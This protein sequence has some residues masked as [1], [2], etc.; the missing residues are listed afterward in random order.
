MGR[1]R[2]G[3]QVIMMVA[4]LALPEAVSAQG[5]PQGGTPVQGALQAPTTMVPLPTPA[6]TLEFDATIQA[7]ID[8]NPTVLGAA[9]NISRAEALLMQ[10]RAIERP[11]ASAS[12]SDVTINTSAVIQGLVISPRS[13]VTLTGD[14]SFAVLSAAKWAQVAQA[15]DQVDVAKISTADVRRQVAVAAA[16]AYLAVFAAQRQLA[17]D[18]R[19]VS[20]AQAHLDYAQKRLQ[21]G[22]GS[23]LDAQRAA[24]VVSTDQAL[25]ENTRLAL[26]R[27]EEA[28]GVLVATDG[29]VA[30]GA[31]PVFETPAS[32]DVAQGL[33]ARTDVQLQRENTRADERVLRDSGK[34]WWPTGTISFDPT[35]IVPAGLFQLSK[36]WRLSL[37]FTQ[38][39]F[40]GGQRR[41]MKLERAATVE[42]SKQSEA[43]VENQAR[44][45]IRQAEESIDSLQ[46]ALVSSQQAVAQAN[47]VLQITTTSFELGAT[48]NLDVIDAERTARD[49]ETSAATAEDA[50]R[51][52]KLDLLVAL[53]RFPR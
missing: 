29:P 35:Y 44:S 5:A 43:S 49:A 16:E 21:G 10:A 32:L 48:T 28:L 34:D 51:R 45:D 9:T 42:Q 31:E 17:V 3:A 37:T 30:V 2:Q 1:V 18:A 40:D 20:N 6:A 25:L 27:S 24:Q 46:R 39:L 11:T 38:P 14:V 13:Q 33:S 50:V 15:M 12:V 52:A 23:R 53:G 7:A 47:D 4:A 22:V 26:I 36:T 19:A 41:G 8:K